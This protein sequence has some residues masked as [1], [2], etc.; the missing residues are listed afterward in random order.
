MDNP[1]GM[2]NPGNQPQGQGQASNPIAGVVQQLEMQCGSVIDR[3][4]SAIPGAE[5]HTATAKQAISGALRGLQTNLERQAGPNL[6]KLNL[7]GINLGGMMGGG[8][9]QTPP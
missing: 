4:G 6:S 3:L 9:Q 5:Q 7:G 8:S 1:R 2:F